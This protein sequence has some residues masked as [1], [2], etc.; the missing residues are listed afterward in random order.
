MTKVFPARTEEVLSEV[1]GVE[2]CAV[3]VI[4]EDNLVKEQV[5][6]LVLNDDVAGK[7]CIEAVQGYCKE[8]LPAYYAP[9]RYVI[10]DELP[11]T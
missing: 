3:S 1:S 4:L 6:Y 11:L 8:K 7:E 10:L 5:A 2:K 9:D